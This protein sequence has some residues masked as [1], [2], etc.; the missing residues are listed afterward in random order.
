MIGRRTF[1]AGALGAA[2]P[3][4]GAADVPKTAQAALR[5]E[6][7]L[8]AAQSRAVLLFFHASWCSWC[9]V[10]DRL[11][12]DPAA[13]PVFAAH[14]RVFRVRA[15][16]HTDA[17]RALELPGAD[18][19]Y[20]HYAGPDAG[21]PFYLVVDANGRAIATSASPKTGDNIGFPVEP[22]E[23][24]AFAALLKTGAPDI[25]ALEQKAVREACVRIM[26]ARR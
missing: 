9:H 6:L 7:E 19:L 25:T 16:E 3:G 11:L 2:L 18:M 26:A 15:Q 4:V 24:D 20:M 21:L 14:F 10:F 12:D 1:L 13:A 23:L 17:N 5:R 8:A 22:A